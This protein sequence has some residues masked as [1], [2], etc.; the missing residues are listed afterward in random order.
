MRPWGRSRGLFRSDISVWLSS[1]ALTIIS[2]ITH[3]VAC[4]L[5]S[6]FGCQTVLVGGCEL[7]EMVG[8]TDAWGEC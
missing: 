3:P 8:R 5:A 1:K 7:D 2:L 4:D 6:R